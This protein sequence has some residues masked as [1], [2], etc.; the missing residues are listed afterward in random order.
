M[1]I[2]IS[3]FFLFIIFVSPAQAIVN[4]LA[5]PNNQFGIHVL[6]AIDLP[7]AAALVNSR[8]GDWGYVTL[9]IRQDDRRLEK[10]QPI[11]EKL[12]QLHLIPIVRLATYSQNNYWV[13][14]E[15]GDID[16]WVNFLNSLNWVIQNRYV[17]LFNEPNH[18]L[19]WGNSLN[20]SEYSVIVRQFHDKLK[21]ASPDFFILPAGLDTAASNSQSTLSAVNYWQQMY[22]ADPQIF[23]LFDGWNSHSYPNPGF[24]GS[25][26]ATGFGTL[27]SY[28]SET[29]LLRNLNLPSG[30]PVF[31]TET[32]WINSASLSDFYLQAFTKIWT[33]P[34]IVAI[35]PFVLNYPQAPFSQ[36]S[37]AI[38][39]SNEFYQHYYAVQ[40]M[41][42]ITGQPIQQQSSQLISFNLPS[43]LIDSSEYQFS[44]KITNTG[45]SIWQSK[46]YQ[47]IVTGSFPAN[48]IKVNDL[49]STEPFK[50]AEF[51]ITLTT[52]LK[53]Q[54]YIL[55]LQLA[56]HG[57]VFGEKIEQAVSIV[58][59]PSLLV[60]AKLLFKSKVTASNFQLLIYDQTNQLQN[61]LKLS[62]INGVSQPIYLYNLIPNNLY[63]F[64]LLKP[65]YLPRQLYAVLNLRQTEISFKP[66]LPFDLNL[67]QHLSLADFLLFLFYPLNYLGLGL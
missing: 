65:S 12:R 29:D 14:P 61:K 54:K 59:P 28:R 6:E 39:N 31:I 3:L 1:S 67:D 21:N 41:P 7:A 26:F 46:D 2:L 42:K 50:T 47:L 34:N 10:W 52:P 48:S 19:E 15:V 33:Q 43:S 5:V 60:Q 35:T 38:P 23:S 53:R 55:G 57:R 30:L 9:V 45:Q 11:F 27:Q 16:T 58:P 62:L 4:P 51:T 22:Q 8:G 44:L 24:S 17:I 36:F 20:P 18:A 40:A 64:V 56:D 66:L 13:K 37:W 49:T 32:G 63:R 25:P